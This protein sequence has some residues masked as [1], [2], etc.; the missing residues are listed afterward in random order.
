MHIGLIGGIG[1]AATDY[2]YRGLIER[3]AAS[4]TPL[5]LTIAHADA[6]E[7]TRNVANRDARGQAEI[8][9]RLVRRLAAAGAEAAAVTSMGGHFCVR[10][11]EAISPLPIINAIPEV[12]AAIK[13]RKLKRIGIIGTRLVMETGLYGGLSAFEI[14]LPE[15]E[16]LEEVHRNYIEMAIPGRV[17]EAQR[18]LFFS[19]GQQLCRLQGAEAVMLGGTDLFLAFEGQECGFPLLHCAEIHVEAIYRRSV[20]KA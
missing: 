10:E 9:A 5:E 16:A 15:G 11:L 1:P 8:F 18:R 3:H 4:A 12:D 14:V 7:M 6:R 19:V 20:G 2:Y 13:R 17:T